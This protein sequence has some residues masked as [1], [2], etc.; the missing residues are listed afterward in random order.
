MKSTRLHSSAVHRRAWPNRIFAVLYF[1]AVVTLIRRQILSLLNSTI[2]IPISLLIFLADIILSFIWVAGQG[3]KIRPIRRNTHQENLTLII[4]E[5]EFPAIDL[6]ICTADPDKEPPL[7]VVNTVLSVMS[8]D[9]PPEKLSVYVSDD[10]GSQFTLMA[11]TEAVN[12]AAYW[13]PY[14]RRNQIIE[15]CPSV[16][17]ESNPVWVPEFDEIKELYETMKNRIEK[18]LI[19]NIKDK[20]ITGRG[21]PNLIYVSREKRKNIPHNFKAG[22]LNVLVRVSAVMTNAPIILTLDCDMYSNDPQTPRRALCYFVDSSLKDN[23]GYIQFPQAFFGINRDDVYGSEFKFEAKIYP[24]GNDGIGGPTYLGT[25][26]FF[27]RR[28]LFGGPQ[29]F[30]VPEIQELSPYWVVNKSIG[31][32]DVLA[33]ANQLARCDYEAQTLWG[34]KVGYRY[35]SVAED[36]Y[37][38]Y[39]MQCEG[40]R[41]IFCHPRR[42]AF[43]GNS[44]M[45]LFDLLSQVKRWCVGF[46]QMGFSKHSPITFGI[47]FLN[48]FLAFAY[49]YHAFCPILGIAVTIYAFIPQLAMIG[50][51]SIFPKVSDPWFFLYMFLFL[52]AYVQDFV[53]FMLEGWENNSIIKWWN[54]Q[55]MWIIKGLSCYPFA[56]TDFVITNCLGITA[57]RF[58]VTGKV[59]DEELSDRYNRGM[60]E[61]GVESPVFIPIATS[62]M[63]NLVALACGVGEV[64]IIG[65]ERF[66]DLFGQMF[67]AG[68]GVVNSWPIYE[69]MVIRHDPG[70]MP[71]KITLVSLFVTLILSSASYY[72]L[73]NV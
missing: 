16:Y 35:G 59:V 57:P 24:S 20:D 15:R 50:S 5:H 65:N 8:Y 52:G 29:T 40:W 66:K 12:F 67:I 26:A 36:M 69:A 71:T 25:G 64:A 7:S 3:F 62:A 45:S 63:V 46:L 19:E 30:L 31:S 51:I 42:P 2:P 14:C 43:L 68:Y 21:M 70:K 61:F 39:L 28:S 13:L 56:I 49:I 73:R 72:Y 32:P 41:S 37:T 22:A 38:S 1:A 27:N 48:P 23:L 11:F 54:N 10:G 53:V 55:R 58:N 44:A 17:L 6:F 47:R 18:V 60:M 34:S 33:L 9:Y 4:Q